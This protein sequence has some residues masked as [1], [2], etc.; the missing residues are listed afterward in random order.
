[1]DKV[2]GEGSHRKSAEAGRA[3]AAEIA[4]ACERQRAGQSYGEAGAAL[5]KI[6]E[7]ARR[8]LPRDYAR[9]DVAAERFA[10]LVE[11][12]IKA[13]FA[14]AAAERPEAAG[15]I[16]LAAV[17]GF[18]RG[19]LAPYSDVDLLILHEGSAGDAKP[20]VDFILYPLWDSGLKVGQSVHSP[21]SAAALAREDMTAR[22]S[23]LDARLLC[24]SKRAFADFA[25]R[26]EKIRKQTKKQ[27]FRAKDLEREE[28]HQKS[29]QSRFLA[30]PDLKE[31]KGG[32]RD[33]HVLRWLYKYEHDAEIDGPGRRRGAFSA[34]DFR[35][36]KRAER[37]LW[38]VRVQLH[39]LR[40]RADEKLSFDVQPALAERLG[41]ADR[42]EVAAA[43][44]LMR[45]YFVNA[46]EIGRLTRLFSA[47]MEEERLRLS[48]AGL[49]VIPG[50]LLKDE[51]GEKANL[52]LEAGRLHFQNAAAARK[53]PLDL[54]RL[55]RAFSKRP[56]FDFHPDALAI[57]ASSVAKITSDV[58]R[59]PAAARL[60]LAA[61]VDG[62]DPLKLLR[63]MAE[64]G[65]L[66][67][68][69]PTFGKIIGR[70]EYG[71]YRRFSIDEGVFQ[72][73][74]VLDEIARGQA[75]DR[76]PIATRILA[77]AGSRAPFYVA[78]LL[79]EARW[80][81]RG[82]ETE[83]VERLIARI[84]RRLG[85]SEAE[86]EDVAWS[87]ARHA[88]LAETA[89]RRNISRPA[90][91][92]RFAVDVARRE[93]LDLLLVLGVCRYRVVGAYTWDD[94]TRR[95]IADLYEGAAAYLGG[96]EAAVA[97]LLEARADAS[98]QA[99]AARLSGWTAEE[100]AR[101]LGAV[102]DG[103][104]KSADPE[105]LA[106]IADLMRSAEGE[107]AA[108]AVSARLADGVVE[109]IVLA[110]DRRGLL[111]DLAGA[112]A[113]A[114]GSV[115][116]V[117]GETR[118]DGKIID[119]FTVQSIDGAPIIDPEFV[120]RLHGTLLAAAHAAPKR[121]PQFSRRI[122]DRRAMFAVA[123]LVRIEDE[124]RHLIVE[125]EGQDRPGLLYDLCAAL[126][127]L[128]IEIVSA[129]IA[130]Y[131]AKAVD[132]FYVVDAGAAEGAG[133][134]AEIRSRLLVALGDGGGPRTPLTDRP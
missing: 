57:V 90:A 113:A 73:I 56:E 67:K 70:I 17:G 41:Y 11:E 20:V 64:T 3:V 68:Y 99:A 19:L 51:A 117:A 35:A 10:A 21:Q 66:G 124:D 5:R 12:A 102:P 42:G 22:T 118:A 63:V 14:A 96:G 49:R 98:R 53:Q 78:M 39:A 133:R 86:A 126:S 115:R 116:S 31:G 34:E 101:I 7:A 18:G 55:F 27:F 69:V 81:M 28:R 89:E 88:L 132:A 36:F 45:H 32:L 23:F 91:I 75:R 111:A 94:W 4:A 44:R 8:S 15:K 85:L 130:T 2:A 104:A 76:H 97:R 100:R 79:H 9:G 119:L 54:F 123:P 25:Q 48:P 112:I 92:A 122:G 26:F 77:A 50:A 105:L 71:L 128:D 134:R 80:S 29:E 121:P 33:L 24:G 129:H 46:M 37:F 13:L 61:I 38:S 30:E 82:A 110:D 62:K 93:R 106:R 1:M 107:G 74:G 95:R 114:G 120:R 127:A 125:T 58:R 52:K 6:I 83:A 40:G 72:A 16:A 43:E 87:A 108:A 60:F 65:L 103:I 109:A 47:R 131:G 59:D 84:A